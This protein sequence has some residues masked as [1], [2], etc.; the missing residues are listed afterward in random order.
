MSEFIEK[1]MSAAKTQLLADSY[2]ICS[3]YLEYGMGGSTVQAAQKSISNIISI[4]NNQDLVS[5]VKTEI[6]KSIYSGNINLLHANL[7]NT[8]QNG[9][10][11]NETTLKAWPQYYAAPWNEYKSLGLL[12]DLILV[13]GRLRTPCFLYSILQCR[14]GTRILWNDYLNKPE[15]HFVEK[16]LKPQG[17][18]EDMVIFVVDKNIDKNLAIDLL[19]QNLFNLD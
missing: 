11:L 5:E 14:T 16:L 1:K 15:Y 7:G 6:E 3:N 10:P 13:N 4:D 9:F 2:F 19:F 17:L 18:V 8:S 12:P